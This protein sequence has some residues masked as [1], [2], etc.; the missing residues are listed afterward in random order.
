MVEEE[1]S[2]WRGAK[3]VWVFLISR[4]ARSSAQQLNCRDGR[5]DG[6]TPPR[7]EEEGDG[8]SEAFCVCLYIRLEEHSLGIMGR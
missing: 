8:V 4:I 1:G 2:H 3:R 7:Y 6:R 5:T